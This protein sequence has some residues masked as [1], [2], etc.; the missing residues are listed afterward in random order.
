[1]NASARAGLLVVP[2]SMLLLFACV[3]TKFSPAENFEARNVPSVSPTAVRVLRSAPNEPFQTLGEIMVEISGLH[4]GDTIIRKARER[5]ATVGADA[6]IY[7]TS[8]FSAV[9]SPNGPAPISVGTSQ[10]V[11]V[12]FTAV[13][14][15]EDSSQR[16]P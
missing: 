13:R 11:S 16:R 14:L 8:Q 1:M 9:A 5:A 15:L 7:K 12:S 3:S 2:L 6:I 4:S 10:L